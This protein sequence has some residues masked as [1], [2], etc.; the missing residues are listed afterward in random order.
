MSETLSEDDFK[1]LVAKGFNR[2]PIS[3]ALL[4]DTETP[5]SAYNKLA[6]GPHSYL[7]ESVQGGERWGRYSIIGLPASQWLTVSGHSV[8]RYQ[9]GQ[10]TDSFEA[11][12]P[13]AAVDD[14]LSAYNSAPMAHLPMFHGGWVGYF[15]YDTV[16]YVEPRLAK[17]GPPDELGVPDIWLMLS[18]EVVIFDNLS[19]AVLKTNLDYLFDQNDASK[20]IRVIRK[21]NVDSLVG[22]LKRLLAID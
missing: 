22:E 9:D 16:R 21:E 18:E 2:I 20:R 11:S 4:A 6:S 14:V 15:G 5:L 1:A 19:G 3:R 17:T 7:F 8:T 10:P 13:L 12:D